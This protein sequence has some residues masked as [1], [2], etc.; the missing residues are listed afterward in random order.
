MSTRTHR[1][2]RQGAALVEFSLTFPIIVF[3]VFGFVEFCSA[4][5]YQHT[6]D[7]AAYEAAR[8]V[9]VPGATANEAIATAE[10]LLARARITDSTIIVT[11]SVIE[12]DTSLVTVEVQIP[13]E[14]NSWGPGSWFLGGTVSSSVTLL[15]ERSPIVRITGVPAIKAKR[16][17]MNTKAEL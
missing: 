17:R 4:F 9:M 10:T 7:T 16:T 3:S 8:A 12:E 14:G 15:C 5:L 2:S 11:P 13:M 1:N 6:A